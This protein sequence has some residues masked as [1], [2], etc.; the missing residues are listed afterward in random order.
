MERTAFEHLSFDT[1]PL[2]DA[3]EV[4]RVD[5]I[6][7]DR[8][9]EHLGV[10]PAKARLLG[11]LSRPRT[12]RPQCVLLAS[13]AGSGKTALLR[14]LQ[15]LYPDR[16][17]RDSGRIVRAVVYSEVEPAPSIRGLQSALLTELG[18]PGVDIRHR[19]WRNDL[20]KRY[21]SEFA[22]ELVLFDEV[23]HLQAISRRE[24][25]L[26]L[27]WMKWVSTAGKAS[28]VLSAA[29]ADGRRLIEHDAQLLTRFSEVSIARF[30]TGAAFGQFLLTL[31]RSMPLRRASGLAQESMQRAILDESEAMQT[32]RGLTDGVVKVVQEAAVAAVTSGTE[33]IEL[34]LLAAWRDGETVARHHRPAVTQGAAALA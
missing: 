15:R 4:T 30:R 7:R 23:Q 6:R 32:L 11:L 26:L 9:I 14:H 22:V 27:D 1:R 10:R 29:I 2:A 17:E 28:V 31:E 16:E 19:E 33:R 13:E 20:I 24:R 3:D 12:V 5:Y 21:L 8:F 18:A 25:I 34:R